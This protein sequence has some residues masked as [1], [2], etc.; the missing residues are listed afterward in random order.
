MLTG[1]GSAD[2]RSPNPTTT[3]L[4]DELSAESLGALLA[5]YEHKAFCA[6]VTWGI[7]PFDQPGVEMGKTLAQSVHGNLAGRD[8]AAASDFST[9]GLVDICRTLGMG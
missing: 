9:Q 2:V 1:Q 7:N 4:V 3:I 6:G 8:G 5:L